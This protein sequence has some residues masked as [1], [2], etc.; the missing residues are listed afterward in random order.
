QEIGNKSGEGVTC[1]NLALAY[2]R[3]GNLSR[4]IEHAQRTVDIEE[5]T[6]HPDA[7]QSREFLLSLEKEL[8]AANKQ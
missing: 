5:E 8:T 4:A 1:W 6:Q 2:K 7:Q 3:R